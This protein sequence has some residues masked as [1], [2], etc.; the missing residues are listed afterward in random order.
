MKCNGE[1]WVFSTGRGILS[2]R[3]R[4]LAH[5]EP[6]PPV[7][8]TPPAWTTNIV[9][10]HRGVFWAPDLIRIGNR[11]LLY[12]SVSAWGKKTSAIGLAVSPTLDP[13]APGYGWT[14]QGFVIRSGEADDFNAI[15]PAVALDAHGNLWLAFGSYWSGIKL[16][17]L[18]ALTGK[19]IQPG[20]TVYPLAHAAA[21]EAACVHYYEGRYYLFVNWGA[22]CR[23]TNSTYSIRVGRSATIA[24][25]YLDK[26][27]KDLLQGGGT[28]LLGS[29]GRFIGPGH[30]GL[31][32]ESGTI[33]EDG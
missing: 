24:G 18:N 5:W 17:Q 33:S 9:P 10:D 25:P 26:D 4:D 6:G 8:Q 32:T 22:C 14:D 29:S 15:D 23:G 7:F 28:L 30:A 20:S 31:F 11:Y 27:G 19:R 16:V 13:S 3:S 12:Y 2:R 1:Y 21:I